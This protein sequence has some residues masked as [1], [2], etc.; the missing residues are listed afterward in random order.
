MAH[1]ARVAL[2]LR[3]GVRKGS[4]RMLSA[5][6]TCKELP[7]P[8][9]PPQHKPNVG[10]VGTGVSGPPQLVY[11][12][13]LNSGPLPLPLRCW[14][15]SPLPLALCAQTPTI[16]TFALLTCFSIRMCPPLQVMGSAMA[17]RILEQ[18]CVAIPLP[19][20]ECTNFFAL[21]SALCHTRQCI[22]PHS[23]VHSATLADA[24]LT[25]C[26]THRCLPRTL[27]SAHTWM[28]PFRTPRCFYSHADA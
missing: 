24:S 12:E 21:A 10:F 18:G 1:S 9:S 13:Y 11:P 14:G 17:N 4:Q 27:P 22:L 2:A 6:T 20:R 19:S 25:S 3:G 23:P 7:P 26:R 5:S 8:P 16:L 28:L 15:S